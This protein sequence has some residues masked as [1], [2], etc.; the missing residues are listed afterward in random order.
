MSPLTLPHLYGGG[1]TGATSSTIAVSTA[2]A[3]HLTIQTQ[4]SAS[5]TAG[6]VL[7]Q[8]PKVRIEDAFGNLI[9]SDN[10]TLVTVARNAGSG[11]LQG[12]VTATAVSGV[13]SFTNLSHQVANTITIGF[14]NGSLVG[15]VSSNIVV[16]SASATRLAFATQ[17]G[18]AVAGSVFAIQPVV[19][20]QDQFGNSSTVGLSSNRM[21]SIALTSGTGPLQGST[22]L[23]IGTNA[24]KVSFTNLR[25]DGRDQTTDGQRH[26]FNQRDSS[27][28]AVSSALASRLMIQTQPRRRHCG[29]GV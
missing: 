3:D 21:V 20:S 27:S 24:G 29:L 22:S 2:T 19:N 15:A 14:S 4:P 28:F 23:D 7:T 18:G 12:T 16:N 10:S 11:T 9:S 13:A 1:L 26:Q 17:P 5:A 25:I 8:Q 6:V